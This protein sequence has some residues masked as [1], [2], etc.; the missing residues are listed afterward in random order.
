MTSLFDDVTGMEYEGVWRTWKITSVGL[1]AV[2][3]ACIVDITI[4]MR[5]IRP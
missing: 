4:S 5:R 1:F 3:V 2:L